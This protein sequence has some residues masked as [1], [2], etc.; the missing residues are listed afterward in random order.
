MSKQGGLG[1]NFYVDGIDVSND[2]GNLQ[3]I[4]TPRT[5]GVITGIDKYAFERKLLK[6]DGVISGQAHWNPAGA[7]LAFNDL[8]TADRIFS[9]FR[10][11]AI[12]SPVASMVAKQINWDGSRE[13]EGLFPF[14]FNAQANAY[15]LEWGEQLTVGKRTDTVATNGSSFDGGAATAFGAQ[16]WLHLFAFTGTSVTIKIQDSADGAAW[17]DLAGAT[18]GALSAV[19]ALRI[20]LGLT[21]TVRRYMRVV[22]TGT[23]SNAV[24]AVQGTRNAHLVAF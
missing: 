22:T 24:F 12:G 2:M 17:L 7:Q 9:Y 18:F 11:A 21:D 19:T 4:S 23:F 15:P 1:D 16:F 5:N 13:A 6:R 10:G 14:A 3:T 20:Q 8:P